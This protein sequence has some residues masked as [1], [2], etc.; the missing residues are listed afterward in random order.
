MHQNQRVDAATRNDRGPCDGLAERG[1]CA[2]Y[3]NIVVQHGGNGILLVWSQGSGELH[4]DR[5]AVYSFVMY[6]AADAIAS[7]QFL[8]SVQ[9]T[10]R[11][12]DVLGGSSQHSR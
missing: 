7:K 1:R 5:R 6:V 2:E 10:A 11:K 3:A 12:A 8:C 4:V 9:A